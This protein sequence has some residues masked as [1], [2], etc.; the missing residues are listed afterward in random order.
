MAIATVRLTRHELARS[1]LDR[2]ES[3]WCDAA[4][5][6]EYRQALRSALVPAKGPAALRQPR[7]RSSSL[8]A[9]P[10]L[11]C[12]AAGGD[13]RNAELAAAAWG[14]LYYAAHLLDAV[15]DCQVEMGS[16][17]AS[18]LGTTVNVAIGLMTGAGLALDALEDSG[19]SPKAARD[20]RHNFHHAVLTMCSGPHAD[21]TCLAPSLEQCWQ[22]AEA[23][24]GE[25]FSLA[26]SAG[27]RLATSDSARIDRFAL[28]GQHLG[29]I[30]Q[31][32]DDLDGLSPVEGEP[33]DLA[34]GGSWTLP[35]AYTMSVMPAAERDQLRCCLQAA[36]NDAAAS[37]E[38][39]RRII[40]SGAVLYLTVEA[41]RRRR[42]ANAALM[43]ASQ[44]GEARDDLL[45][46]LHGVSTMS[47][48]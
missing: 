32:R 22:T 47:N 4:V 27:A 41:E 25:F 16:P 23:K 24:S 2:I 11:C 21:L 1:I 7:F 37:A 39:R 5:E 33:S 10:G 28:F 35:V 46:L 43:A 30:I 13:W 17:S 8:I 38:A 36:T 20:V 40:E 29:S 45:A 15:E 31:I 12:E 19:A 14:L 48:T 42:Q 18:P 44:P 6:P 3:L 26:C 34:S 9:L